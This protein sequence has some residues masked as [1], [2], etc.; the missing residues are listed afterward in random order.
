M[1]QPRP[2]AILVDGTSARFAVEGRSALRHGFH[3]TFDHALSPTGRV[4]PAL[5]VSA[6]SFR[7]NVPNI[8]GRDVYLAGPP[9]FTNAVSPRHGGVVRD[10]RDGRG[11]G[12]CFDP[13][14]AHTSTA[15]PPM[16]RAARTRRRTARIVATAGD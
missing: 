15:V 14:A 12:P 5:L 16:R 1:V 2:E 13:G 9:G 3:T 7:Q 6:A 10:G 8:A 4:E 11:F